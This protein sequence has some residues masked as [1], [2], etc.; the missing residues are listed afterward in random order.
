MLEHEIN[1]RLLKSVGE[2]GSSTHAP[3]ESVFNWKPLGGGGSECEGGE[4]KCSLGASQPGYHHASQ[5]P[6]VCECYHIY[7]G[8]YS[9]VRHKKVK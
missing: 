3:G 6:T 5:D 2:V 8:I 9:N 1:S 4:K 7:P